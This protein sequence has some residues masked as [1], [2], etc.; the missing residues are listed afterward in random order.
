M[1][2]SFDRSE[3]PTRR[4]LQR[5][6]E[7]GQVARSGDLSSALC[8]L[9]IIAI[10]GW[11]LP[12]LLERA[13]AMI[14]D[15][16]ALSGG[17][18]EVALADSAWWLIEMVA[19]AGGLLML[20]AVAAGVLQVGGLCAPSVV[21]PDP[22]R[23]DP[24]KGFSRLFGGRGAMRAVLSA[25]KVVLVPGAVSAVLI[26]HRL[27]L[28]SLSEAPSSLEGLAALAPVALHAAGAGAAVLLALGSC[29]LA[30]QRHA[31]RADL[32]MT[33]REVMD[34]RREL[35][36]DAVLRNR[37]RSTL[38]SWRDMGRLAGASIVVAGEE[39]AVAIAWR[40][41]TM[42]AP[43]V[44][45]EARGTGAAAMVARAAASGVPVAQ[46]PGLAS[47]LFRSSPVG[48]GVPAPLHG[49]I[50]IALSSAGRS[51]G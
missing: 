7:H 43:L 26:H 18:L 13:V 1:H 10:C 44:V 14:S 32:K 9:A 34:E 30:W 3:Q 33:R 39:I 47:S 6:R 28:L 41:A 5:A 11:W 2:D 29:D 46:L 25:S 48:G 21:A 23:L 31:W 50:A 51:R 4:R 17:S 40:G 24:L 49:E 36:G 35:E 20:A 8:V 27:A 15:S 45:G 37:R 38:A 16:L 22:G 12:R 42:T 19:V